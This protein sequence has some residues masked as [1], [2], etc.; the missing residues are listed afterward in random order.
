[1]FLKHIRYYQLL[2]THAGYF[3][4]I[5]VGTNTALAGMVNT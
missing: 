4:T 1:M 2:V 5:L 3:S